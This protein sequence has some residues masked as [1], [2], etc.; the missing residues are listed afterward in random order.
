[1]TQQDGIFQLRTQEEESDGVQDTIPHQVLGYR[2]QCHNES[3]CTSV[4]A[5]AGCLLGLCTACTA[6]SVLLRTRAAG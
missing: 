4:R 3:S 2:I 6:F 5:H 1:M